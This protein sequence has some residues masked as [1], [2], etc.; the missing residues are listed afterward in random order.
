[1][2]GLC[3]MVA[4]NVFFFLFGKNDELCAAPIQGSDGVF[5]EPWATILLLAADAV[6]A[7][8][9]TIGV[10]V[11]SHDLRSG[12]WGLVLSI[13]EG[14]PNPHWFSPP[15]LLHRQPSVPPPPTPSSPT[16]T[17]L[18]SPPRCACCREFIGSPDTRPRCWRY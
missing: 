8:A 4:K 17:L 6:S 12:S 16:D 18:T 10:R 9:P 7:T 2:I 5:L 13:S 1:M 15:P 3:L 14:S 11:A